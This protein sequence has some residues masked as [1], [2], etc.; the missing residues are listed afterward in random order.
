MRTTVPGCGW[1]SNSTDNAGVRARGHET[2][3]YTRAR[4]ARIQARQE[5]GKGGGK[6][7]MAAIREIADRLDGKPMAAVDVTSRH[8]ESLLTDDQALR[9][10]QEYIESRKRAAA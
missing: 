2:D 3:R 9:I 1:T 6:G 10:A 5:S 7:E 8:T 4:T